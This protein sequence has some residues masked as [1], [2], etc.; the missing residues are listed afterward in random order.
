MSPSIS[1]IPEAM[2]DL[3]RS[4]SVPAQPPLRVGRFAFLTLMSRWAEGWREPQETGPAAR[5]LR[6]CRAFSPRCPGSWHRVR[7]A[8]WPSTS[9][10]SSC[11]PH[12][13]S[14]AYLPGVQ[15]LA[16]SLQAVGSRHALICMHTDGVS[17]VRRAAGGRGGWPG[18]GS[19][20]SSAKGSGSA[21]IYRLH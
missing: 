11:P 7:R 21:V 19:G 6:L 9:L 14:D 15:C 10:I 17:Q 8:S 18:V 2:V 3:P 12:L 4:L 1:P 20:A 5:L 13:H 16:Q